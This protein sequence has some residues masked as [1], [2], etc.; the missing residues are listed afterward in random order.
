MKQERGRRYDFLTYA[1]CLK[2]EDA[3]PNHHH[4]GS[5]RSRDC[6]QDV[7]IPGGRWNMDGFLVGGLSLP[8]KR[9]CEYVTT[10]KWAKIYI[11]PERTESANCLKK[12][13]SRNNDYHLG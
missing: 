6:P 11:Y 7:I 8:E 1:D 2:V 5:K 4:Q 3:E 12:Q 13:L 10:T 9:P